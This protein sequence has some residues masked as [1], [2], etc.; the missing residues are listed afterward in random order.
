M[1]FIISMTLLTALLGGCGGG[2]KSD[3]AACEFLQGVDTSTDREGLKE[4]ADMAESAELRQALTS[5]Y[6]QSPPEGVED[7]PAMEGALDQIGTVFSICSS[8]GVT[9]TD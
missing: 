7:L 9:F 8:E 1:R 5:L 2:G 6:E 4:A 3:K